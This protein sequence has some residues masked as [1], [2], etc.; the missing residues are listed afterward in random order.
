MKNLNLNKI[1]IIAAFL[2]IAI[3]MLSTNT[4]RPNQDTTLTSYATTGDLTLDGDMSETVWDNADS[5]VI[6]NIGSSGA[7]VTVYSKQ[8]GTHIFLFA[9]WTDSTM[10]NIRKQ[11]EF[12]GTDWENNGFNE[13]RITFFWSN[14][15]I[16]PKCGHYVSSPNVTAGYQGDVWHWKATRTDPAGWADDKYFDGTGRHSDD[17]TSGGYKDN[18]VVAQMIS[19]GNTS[20]EI[21]SVLNNNSA[22][23]AF[24][25]GDLPYW[26]A[27]GNVIT[28]VSGANT[29]VLT[30]IIGGQPTTLPTGS[31]GDVM[32]GSN[33]DGSTWSVEYVRKLDTGH[34]DDDV[35][36]AV[37]NSYTFAVAVHNKSGD[38]AH[39]TAKEL[40]LTVSSDAPTTTTVPPTT[41]TEETTT[42]TTTD[43]GTPGLLIPGVIIG[44]AS[45]VA[46]RSIIRKKTS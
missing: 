24:N 41:T 27:S 32:V 39:F 28:W 38:A 36:F 6:T 37:G 7:D 22:V 23:S 14:S 29:T 16:S 20:G 12:N 8:N 10:D 30:D 18:S 26:D 13:D 3:L 33:H 31:R 4:A 1:V 9:T 34:S 11:W 15:S 42:T 17:K 45:L 25:A 35:M 46:F 44:I 43:A 19:M 5:V 21:T 2:T 40:T